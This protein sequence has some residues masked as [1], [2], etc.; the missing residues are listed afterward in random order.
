[1]SGDK[2][3]NNI[4]EESS[5]RDILWGL[6]FEKILQN[7]DASV[8]VTDS[9]GRIIFINERFSDFFRVSEDKIVGEKWVDVIVPGT[10]RNTAQRI[11]DNMKKRKALGRFDLPVI[12]SEKEQKRFCWIDVPL[13]E[14]H[15]FYYMFI[16]WEGMCQFG[17]RI[18]VNRAI[19]KEL[20]TAYKEV[21]SAIFTASRVADPM[22][23]QHA[24]RVMSFA[25]ALAKKMKMGKE[26][27]EELKVACLLHDLGKLAIDEKILFKKGKLTEREFGQIKK[28]PEWGA[29]IA[30]LIYFLH[31]IIPI[32]A[33]HHENYDGSGYPN[34]LKG[35]EIPLEA[36]VLSVADIYEA[37]TADRPY[38]AG[39]PKEE[40]VKIIRE[41][42]GRKL[43]PAITDIFL[44]IV[45]KG[46]IREEEFEQGLS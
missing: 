40:A 33:D 18:E 8:M 17:R 11:F 30:R 20:S 32:M 28:H 1:M 14:N 25:V 12:T 16:G 46:E 21:I 23:A 41:E 26:K 15:S 4:S 37:L 5:K 22:M 7:I 2:K 3:I 27:I 19:P 13:K 43:D 31:Y 35:E 10:K 24:L 39:Y 44:D 9:R 38:R 29:E 45:E 6:F 36:R 42:R 34:G